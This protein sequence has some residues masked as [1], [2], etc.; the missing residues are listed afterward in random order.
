MV[1]TFTP[2]L[3]A[4]SVWLRPEASRAPVMR[5]PK[6]VASASYQP[7]A[8]VVFAVGVA[9]RFIVHVVIHFAGGTVDG[10]AHVVFLSR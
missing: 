9:V 5:S 8:S 2:S 7:G 6:V 1:L 3:R 4:S 10:V